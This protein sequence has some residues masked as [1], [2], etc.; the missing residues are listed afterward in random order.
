[1][2]CLPRHKALATC[3]VG[4]NLTGRLPHS[5]AVGQ[6]GFEVVMEGLMVICLKHHDKKQH[7]NATA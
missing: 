1:M 2:A 6:P 7:N 3:C 5:Y 4:V